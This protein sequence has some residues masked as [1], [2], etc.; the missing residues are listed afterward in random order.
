VGGNAFFDA[1][2]RSNKDYWQWGVGLEALGR[3]WSFRAN[4]YFPGSNLQ[5]I[6]SLEGGFNNR[7][8]RQ[9]YTG[10]DLE[11]G[12]GFQLW[13]GQA[14]GYAT[15]YYFTGRHVRDIQGPRLRLEYK[16]DNPLI[17]GAEVAFAGEWDY[18]HRHGSTVAGFASVRI[19]LSRCP[20]RLSSS[21][22][23]S[24][25]RQMGDRV[26]REYSI[27]V[28]TETFRFDSL[29]IFVQNS[30][31]DG[32][33]GTQTDPKNINE[34]VMM[35]SDPNGVLFMLEDGGNLL[36][37]EI[38]DGT[39]GTITLE[40]NQ[41]IVGF[42]GNTSTTVSFTNGSALQVDALGSGNRPILVDDGTNPIVTSLSSSDFTLQGIELQGNGSPLFV[43][44]TAGGSGR[45]SDIV[46]QT[47]ANT[48]FLQSVDARLCPG[49]CA[50]SHGVSPV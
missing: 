24:L 31:P 34:A 50:K 16:L 10:F 26:R 21:C 27:W 3:C 14:W 2:G 6:R 32:A 11:A 43:D 8:I 39:G 25:C 46:T 35:L 4:G 7:E 40:S 42:G 29:F 30:A 38:N 5:D 23:D 20:E 19:P 45:F 36:M 17:N 33:S 28:D 1:A 18:N 12:A 37:S 47:A 13:R 15:Y 44:M 49:L 41:Q 48:L 9:A 22:C